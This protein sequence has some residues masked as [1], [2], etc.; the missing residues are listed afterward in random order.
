M[1]RKQFRKWKIKNKINKQMELEI[2]N[3]RPEWAD[4]D[5]IDTNF[6]KWRQNF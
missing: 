6:E 5:Q 2:S 4:E 1:T 3:E